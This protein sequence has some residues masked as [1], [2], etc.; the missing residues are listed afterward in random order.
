M[1]P[2]EP[3]KNMAVI[4]EDRPQPDRENGPQT[5]IGR[6]REWSRVRHWE[7]P[8]SFPASP[9]ARIAEMHENAG[10]R[11]DGIAS[12]MI[13]MDGESVACRPD[14]GMADFCE[15]HEKGMPYHIRARE[16]AYAIH[17]LPESLR[18]VVIEMY[19][20]PSRERPKS[21]RAVAD[22]MGL[23]RLE[24]IRRLERAYGWLGRELG[25]PPI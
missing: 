7:S 3:R 15:R 1:I 11:G 19:G 12:D 2:L 21:D 24:V 4:S 18:V 8:N 22:K 23:P 20:V 10:I 16:T 13:T 17:A 25:L 14:G 6:I 9:F 5:A